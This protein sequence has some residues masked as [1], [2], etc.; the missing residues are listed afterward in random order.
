M[1]LSKRW[2]VYDY[3]LFEART[4][5][6]VIITRSIAYENTVQAD[7]TSSLTNLFME[8]AELKFG[9]GYPN[10]GLGLFGS[11]PRTV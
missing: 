2:K 9:C 1:E 11:P 6:S 5:P 7:E 8:S 3:L 10:I 4:M